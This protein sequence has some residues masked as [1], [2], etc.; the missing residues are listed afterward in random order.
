ME[1][2]MRS[3]RVAYGVTLAL[4]LAGAGGATAQTPAEIASGYAAAALREAPEFNG[5][6]AKRG[7]AFFQSTH[8]GEWSCASCH[9]R[10]PLASGRHAK[11]AKSIAPLAPAANADRFTSLATVD[12][13]FR[14]N[15][16]DVVGRVCTTLEKGDVLAYLMQQKP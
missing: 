3:G 9:T 15:C 5:F 2:L 14:R 11:T 4:I 12:K 10:N 1:V 8:G 7:E 16:N 13:W 6:S